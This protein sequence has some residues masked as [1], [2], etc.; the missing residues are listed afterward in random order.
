MV[1]N[2]EKISKMKKICKNVAKCG[3]LGAVLLLG[4]TACTDDHFDVIPGTVTSSS[5]IW[6]NIQ[7]NGLTDSVAMILSRTI[8][9]DDEYDNKGRQTYADML[10]QPQAFT[11]WLPKDGS[12]NAKHYL[13]LLDQRSAS[14]ESNPA[15]GTEADW[16]INYTVANQFVKNHIARFSYESNLNR[17]KVRMLNEKV[18][19]YTAGEDVFNT[20]S[21]VSGEGANIHSS[22][23]TLH[24]L[25]AASPF[26]YNLYDY[27]GASDNFTKLWTALTDSAINKR[28]WSQDLSTQ[29][30][31]DPDGNMVYIDS[32]YVSSNQYLDR[33]G[34]VIKN[35]DSLYIALLPTDAAWDDAVE[36]VGKLFNFGKS[37]DTE[38]N[39]TTGTFAKT[40]ERGLNLTESQVDSLR[41]QNVSDY[42]I[43][44]ALFSTTSFPVADQTDSASVNEYAR[45]ADSIRST[46]GFYFFNRNKGGVNPIFGGKQPIKASN[47]YIYALDRY[48]IDPAYAW[49]TERELNLSSNYYVGHVSDAVEG[50]KGTW[51]QLDES[52]RNDAVKGEVED[53]AYR[54][55]Y[56]TNSST[57]TVD[58][59]L[60]DLYSTRYRIS[61]V[62]VPNNINTSHIRTDK[63][64]EIWERA[65]FSCELRDDQSLSGA[66]SPA[67]AKT[68]TI[69]CLS[70]SV[71]TVVLFDDVE[72]PKSYVGLPSGNETF[73]VLRFT[74]NSLNQNRGK[75]RSLNIRKIIIEPVRD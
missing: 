12:F 7:T 4:T 42:L 53:N 15:S 39:E 46:S 52:N 29:G 8:V 71:E 2:N 13:D 43:A 20:V 56:N 69:Q 75:C 28:E 40:G 66:S 41:K 32:V 59:R 1:I 48:E 50:T 57:M 21:L 26:A 24:L 19:Y 60:T 30:A 64:G 10:N 55:F 23:G 36:K 6:Q 70:D 61:A 14:F 5:T 33:S 11:V 38:Y 65:T 44:S 62:M 34:A 27:L 58:F 68:S 73:V 49:V 9:Q 63:N 16:N 47:G 18:C 74:M 22:N 51:V 67:F 35:E 72:I 31:M 45:M 3:V 17:Q 25:E 54:R 37:Y